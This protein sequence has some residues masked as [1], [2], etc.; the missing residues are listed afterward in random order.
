MIAERRSRVI[1]RVVLS[2]CGKTIRIATSANAVVVPSRS[3][4][5]ADVRCGRCTSVATTVATTQRGGSKGKSS[6]QVGG[7][8]GSRVLPS[9]GKQATI[10]ASMLGD[11]LESTRIGLGTA[12]ATRGIADV[13]RAWCRCGDRD[14]W[15]RHIVGSDIGIRGIGIDAVGRDNNRGE[16]GTETFTGAVTLF[17][18]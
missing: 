8:A 3:S 12:S 6:R 16:F 5:I 10:A 11:L 4:V 17:V 15:R 9:V 14:G 18:L 7:V 13:D 1:V 2:T